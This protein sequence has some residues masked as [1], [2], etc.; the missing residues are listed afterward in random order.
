M[1]N[2][3][4]KILICGA[5]GFIGRNILENF[6]EKS[7]FDVHAT[8][9]FKKKIKTKNV[10]WHKVDLRK[11]NYEELF[12]NIDVVVQS[13]A[14]TSGANDIIN[15]PSLHVT[16]NVIMN[17]YIFKFAVQQKVK[18]LIFFSCTV[19]YHS[20]LKPIRESDFNSN[21]NLYP[22]YY[23]VGHTKLYLEKMCN[24]YSKIGITKFTAIRHSNI[25]GP[26]DKYDLNKSHF[27]G[28]SVSKIFKSKNEVAVWGKGEEKRDLLYVDDLINFVNLAIR[29]QKIKFRIYN[30]GYGKS[31]SINNI[32]N[33]IIKISGKKII[34]KNDLSKKSINTNVCINS[35][36]AKKELGWKPKIRLEE[37]IKKT[38]FWYK[39]NY[40]DKNL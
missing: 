22:N 35:N 26:Y 4:I 40:L 5:T 16:D 12:K 25:Y 31:F 28:A 15:S 14:T 24:F 2:K 18:H 3:K 32:V 9:N 21:K 37:G 33:K 13:A 36:L 19:M 30:C 6:A 7:N 8:Y 23:G 27:F 11:P 17:S 29:R 39:K 1:K 34:R 20:Q 10:Q 38:I